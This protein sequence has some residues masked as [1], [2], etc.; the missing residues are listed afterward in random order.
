MS[1]YFVYILGNKSNSV[2]YTGVTNNLDRRIKEHRLKLIPGFT[3]RYNLT[4]LLYYSRFTDV[5]EALLWEKRIK[6]WLRE[7]KEVLITAENPT[8]KDLA[9]KL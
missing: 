1:D 9:E 3:A 2:L 4:K 5:N 8:W 6:G 7:K